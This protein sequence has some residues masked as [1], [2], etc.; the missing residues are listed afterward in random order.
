M[1]IRKCS[2]K[3][4]SSF[5]LEIRN[6][7]LFHRF[8]E[9]NSNFHQFFPDFFNILLSTS[10]R[11]QWI[12]F[13]VLL[14]HPLEDFNIFRKMKKLLNSLEKCGSYFWW[15]LRSWNTVVETLFLRFPSTCYTFFFISWPFLVPIEED[16][17]K[18]MPFFDSHSAQTAKKT[19]FKPK[20][21]S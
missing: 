19:R 1:A 12:F 11:L 20:N 13:D 4:T 8:F 14:L 16:T 3:M 21:I 5:G 10:A 6:S 7:R 18:Q 15:S 2:K 17:V 9:V